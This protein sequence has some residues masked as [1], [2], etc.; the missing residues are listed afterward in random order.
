MRIQ[1]LLEGQNFDDLKWVEIKGDK[2]EPNFDVAD[3][4]MF[5]MNNDDDT[6][7]RHTYPSIV[8]CIN[9]RESKKKTSPDIFKAAVEESYKNYLKKFPL[10]ELPSSID[11]KLCKETCDKLHEEVTQ[12]I[13]DG[14]YKG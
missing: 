11:E 2:R 4:L 8:K 6:Y 14:K 7:R 10:R 5:F 13:T 1:D 9:F 12:H 3:D